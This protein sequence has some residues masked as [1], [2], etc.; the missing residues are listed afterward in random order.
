MCS[1]VSRQLER[2]NTIQ[3]LDLPVGQPFCRQDSGS[4][5]PG[6][7]WKATNHFRGVSGDWEGKEHNG[8]KQ[9]LPSP[10]VDHWYSGELVSV[11]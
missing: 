2:N 6:S 8:G 1:C 11:W 9:G 10:P 5:L 7:G 4:P 3:T